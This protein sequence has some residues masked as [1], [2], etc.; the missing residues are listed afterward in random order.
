MIL[1]KKVAR[2]L[3]PL[4]VLCTL[5]LSSVIVYYK[6]TDRDLPFSVPY[7]EVTTEDETEESHIDA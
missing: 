6:L 1:F 3:L 7:V 2:W 4:C 5:A